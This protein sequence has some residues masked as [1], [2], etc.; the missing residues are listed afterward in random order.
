[1][2]KVFE[3]DDGFATFGGE[4]DRSVSSNCHVLM[5]L[6]EWGDRPRYS[7]QIRK[8]A[9]FVCNHWWSHDKRFKDKWHLSHLYPTMLMVEAFSTLLRDMEKRPD[10]QYLDTELVQKVAVALFQASMR[11][12]FEQRSNGSWEGSPEQ[13]AYAILTLAEARHFYL[14]HEFDAQ[15]KLAIHKGN[16]FLNS[17][18]IQGLQ[19]LWTSKTS[20][21]V[22][23]VFEAYI[24]AAR[25]K[26][27]D[28]EP[29]QYFGSTLGLANSLEKTLAH[30]P[31]MQKATVFSTMDDVQLRASFVEAALFVPFLQA[32]RSAVFPR[33]D[34][35]VAKEK[36]LELIPFTWVGSNNR[37]K[38]FV[39]NTLLLDLM[40]MAQ[41]LFYSDE[42]FEST[43]ATA[44][45]DTAS[46]AG[47]ADLHTAIDRA[48]TVAV[49]E[50]KL[51]SAMGLSSGYGQV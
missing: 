17:S 44:F 4:R 15:L 8:A 7:S 2:I 6:L 29:P 14:C 25:K 18:H 33:Y 1:M 27:T 42:F 37:S 21:S 38:H 35:K 31:I 46:G 12:L 30:K 50:V 20:Y 10:D 41:Y 11:T 13:T 47:E 26:A 3:K 19:R 23:L 49:D 34:M 51:G 9:T 48:I 28:I 5:A 45:E 16:N 36:Y 40:Y 32:G 22:K 39:P 43:V 24:L